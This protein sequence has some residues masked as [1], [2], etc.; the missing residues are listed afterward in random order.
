MKDEKIRVPAEDGFRMPGEFEPHSGCLMIWP[1]RPGSWKDD[2]TLARRAF[3]EVARAIAESEDLYMLADPEDL[4]EAKRMLDAGDFMSATDTYTE[5]LSG[6]MKA[7][8]NCGN[9]QASGH[10]CVIPM[11]TDDS[12]ARDVGPTF[13]VPAKETASPGAE[14]AEVK[15]AA[16][17][18]EETFE[19]KQP[20]SLEAEEIA[21]S[22]VK[23]ADKGTF[24]VRNVDKG[25]SP[26]LR[27][28]DWRF[29]AWGG[30]VDGLYAGWDLDDQVAKKFCDLLQVPCYDAHPFV[31]EGGSIHTDGQG[32]VIVTESCLL[33][34]GRNPSMTKEQITE[35]LC[36][37][38]GAEK[39]IW[40]PYGIYNDET[41]E[42]VDNVCAFTKP[43]EVV[44]AWT[45]DETDPQYAM[46]KADLE[47]LI[48]ETDAKG[49]R[50]KVVKLPVPSKPICIQEEDLRGFSFEEGEDIR[51]VGERLAA[52]YVN[53]YISN[54]AVIL[55]QFGDENDA[56]AVEI[57]GQCFPEREIKP[58]YARDILLGGGNIHCITQQIPG[59]GSMAHF[60][61]RLHAV[62]EK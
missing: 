13:V 21:A 9:D 32:T 41:N 14:S 15:P 42:H 36:A 37:W 11:K 3:A 4:D 34:K 17:L 33:S 57:L 24:P 28:I 31:L 40:L 7:E 59:T 43:G 55:P 19:V 12:W 46:S 35:K 38:L 44:L 10:I 53:F 16:S 23:C 51:E 30:E 56:L 48:A 50:I 22:Q 61:T 62:Q 1:K 25:P 5:K 29:N 58:I 6:K 54:G 45:D 2:P 49:R 18:E 60:R 26:V 47:L 27:G 20:A 39:V 8:E 52:S